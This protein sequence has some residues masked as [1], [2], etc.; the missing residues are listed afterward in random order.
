MSVWLVFVASL[1]T[2]LATGLGAIPFLFT[3]G[4]RTWLG[5]GDAFA[6]GMMAAATALLVYEG[7]RDDVALTAA[8]A[9]LGAGFMVGTRRLLERRKSLTF[10]TLQGADAVKAAAIVGAMTVHS[11]TEGAGAGRFL[12]RRLNVSAF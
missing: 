10:A 6:A 9:L 11:F 12:R 7:G 3:R 4:S 1:G 8:G 5:L 2:A